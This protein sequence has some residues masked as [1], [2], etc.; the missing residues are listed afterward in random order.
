[1]QSLTTQSLHSHYTVTTQSYTITTQSLHYSP[2]YT[3]DFVG[4]H[5]VASQR[6]LTAVTG[7]AANQRVGRVGT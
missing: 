4:R 3:A 1:M 5:R 6:P 7:L 2:V